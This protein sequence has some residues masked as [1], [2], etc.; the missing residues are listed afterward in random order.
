MLA[1]SSRGGS[2][3][4][5]TEFCSTDTGNDLEGIELRMFAHTM[6]M[7]TGLCL[8]NS[9]RDTL[10]YMDKSR[11]C[12]SNSAL[13]TWQSHLLP[14]PPSYVRMRTTVKHH[15]AGTVKRTVLYKDFCI[16]FINWGMTRLWRKTRSRPS[17][18]TCIGTDPNRN[19]GH[20]WMCHSVKFVNEVYVTGASSNPCSETY[21]GTH[22]FSES[23][24][25]AYH[26]YIL[27][28]KD[29]IKLYL[30]THSYGNVSCLMQPFS[31][32]SIR[33]YSTGRAKL[34]KHACTTGCIGARRVALHT[35]TSWSTEAEH[36]TIRAYSTGRAKLFKHACTTGCIGARR[37]ALHTST[38]W[39]T[40]AEH[41]TTCILLE[42]VKRV[43]QK[44]RSIVS[45]PIQQFCTLTYRGCYITLTSVEHK[46]A[47]LCA[48]LITLTSVEHKAARLCAVI[49][50]QTFK[51]IC[52]VSFSVLNMTQAVRYS[53]HKLLA[54]DQDSSLELSVN[55]SLVYCESSSLDHAVTE[56]GALLLVS[57]GLHIKSTF[58]L[59][60]PC[61]Q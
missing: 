17:S 43:H 58:R 10:V 27:G 25:V 54:P 11:H 22:A 16:F 5:L 44:G 45:V 36:T 9:P 18:S 40:E 14:H 48:V 13:S 28:N 6:K 46:A 19:F 3:V 32:P 35:S 57:M 2:L 52:S 53:T 37:V 41:T 12:E 47:R 29:R 33:A 56:V 21:G 30:A 51:I 15:V 34:F 8:S 42:Q 31:S 4:T 20:H 39:S 26:N 24:T 55:S 7:N 49:I 1:R 60:K 61:K 50:T 23:E 38:S 59:E